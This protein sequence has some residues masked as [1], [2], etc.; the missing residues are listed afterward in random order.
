MVVDKIKS[1][2]PYLIVP[3]FIIWKIRQGSFGFAQGGK[4]SLS[5]TN[6]GNEYVAKQKPLQTALREEQWCASSC[7]ASWLFEVCS[8]AFAFSKIRQRV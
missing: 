5:K 7:E 3:T 4:E 1:M 2:Y 6:N 8:L